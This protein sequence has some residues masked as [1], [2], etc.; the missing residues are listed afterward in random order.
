VASTR[1]EA[2]SDGVFAIAATLLVLDIH[3]PTPRPGID[4]AH[5]LGR[6]W[7]NYAAYAISF[8]TIG[9]IWINHHAMIRRLRE[10]DHSILALNLALLLSIG[11]LPF[12]TALMAAYLKGTSGQHLAAAVYAGSFLF[13]SIT[14]AATQRHILYPKAHLLEVELS[15]RDRRAILTRGVAGLL[16]Y[17]AATALAAVSPYVT[18]ALCGAIA[19]FYALPR[20]TADRASNRPAEL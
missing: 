8:T 19:A 5:E 20:T 9:I 3:V 13:M 17:V 4:L 14:F 15:E 1:L 6:E 12:S 16:P 2:F 7:P 11:L 18:L 10:V